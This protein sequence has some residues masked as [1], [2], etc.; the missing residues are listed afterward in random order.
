MTGL[1]FDVQHYCI[2]DGPGVRTG[3]FLQGCPLRCRWCA[4]P[5]S[6]GMSPRL[7]LRSEACVGCGACAE[8]CSTG[9]AG[10]R[11]GKAVTDRQRCTG[12]GK[13]VEV[14]PAGARGLSGR[15][16]TVDE[17][18]EEVCADALFYGDDGG[19]TLTGGECL[20]QADFSAAILRACRAEGIGTCIETCGDVPFAAFE[21]VAPALDFAFYD[22]KLMDG[23]L[24]RRWTGADNARLL[25]NLR[26]LSEELRVPLAVRMPLLPGI[27]DDETN[28]AAMAEFLSVHV[29]TLQYVELLPYHR[30]GEGKRPQLELPHEETPTH[31][32]SPEELEVFRQ[33]LRERGV[34]MKG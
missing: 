8:V 31:V 5:E 14:C 3:V 32:P 2:H 28:A 10:L 7:L 30:L 33:R 25:A 1:V 12:C 11:A 20:L 19:V 24:H 16:M 13:C 9:A 23:A 4:N 34:P 18:M 21:A 15:V 17:V 29:P 27:N 6:H 22:L 26:R